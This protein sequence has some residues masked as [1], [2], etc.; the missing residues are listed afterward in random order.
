[1]HM[2]PLTHVFD[3]AVTDSAPAAAPS[4]RSTQNTRIDDDPLQ[5]EKMHCVLLQMAMVWPVI[6]NRD[7]V[8]FA[9]G[10]AE[11]MIWSAEHARSAALVKSAI[12]S[13]EAVEWTCTGCGELVPENFELCWNC[14][15][16]RLR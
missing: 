6:L 5:L 7:A 11:I 4:N 12:H 3:E 8:E 10:I 2:I 1:M 14:E 13:D 16:N 15:C 9:R